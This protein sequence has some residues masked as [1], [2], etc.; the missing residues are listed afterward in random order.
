MIALRFQVYRKL[1]L[2][3]ASCTIHFRLSYPAFDTWPEAS[4]MVWEEI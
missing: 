4:I 1:R 2:D 3:K